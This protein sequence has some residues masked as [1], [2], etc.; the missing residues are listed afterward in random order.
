MG[1]LADKMLKKAGATCVF[2]RGEG[3]DDK[4][5]AFPCPPACL[6]NACCCGIGVV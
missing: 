2:A 3:D 1:R 5:C 4:R 6:V